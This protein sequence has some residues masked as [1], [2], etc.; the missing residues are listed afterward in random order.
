MI[1]STYVAPLFL[2]MITRK[3]T[4]P[5]TLQRHV[6]TTVGH[7]H[8]K[9]HTLTSPSPHIRPFP[10]TSATSQSKSPS[11]D[12]RSQFQLYPKFFNLV[13]CRQL[14]LA[15]LW[16]LDRSDTTRRRR[17]RAPPQP[18]TPGRDVEG[19]GIQMCSLGCTGLKRYISP[20]SPTDTR[21]LVFARSKT[22]LVPLLFIQSSMLLA[23]LSHLF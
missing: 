4:I 12:L 6:H 13:E 2:I 23:R 22:S 20:P 1:G 3:P 7:S 9:T 10:S 17:G 16:K 8:T 5:Y 14:I 15:G 11:P 19:G 18:D 21:L